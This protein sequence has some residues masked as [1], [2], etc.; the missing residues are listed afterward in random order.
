MKIDSVHAEHMLGNAVSSSISSHSIVSRDSAGDIHAAG[1]SISGSSGTLFSYSDGTRSVYGGCN[2][3]G[4]WFGTS[5]NHDLRLVT[6]SGERMRIDNTGNVGIGTTSPATYL[7]LSANNSDPGATEGDLVGTHTLTEYMR[8]TSAGDSGDVNAVS[9]GFKLG[10]DDNNNV[11][12]DGRLDICANQ[13]APAGNNY[14]TTPDKTIATFLGSGNVGIGTTDPDYKLHIVGSDTDANANY[15][16]AVIDHNCSGGGTNTGDTSHMALLIDMDSTATGGTTGNEHRMYGIKSDTRHSGDSDL[17]YGLYSYARSDHT[18]GTTTE[19]RAGDFYAIAS[20][21]GTNTNIYGINSFAY[22]DAGSTGTTAKMI[23]VRGEVQLNGGECTNAYVFQSQIDHN[24]GTMDTAYLYYGSYSGTVSTKWGIYLTG[25]TKNYF[26]G[27]VGIGVTSPGYKLHV[28]GSIYGSGVTTPYLTGHGYIAERSYT[29]NPTSNTTKYFLGWTNQDSMQIS[30]RDSGWGHGG[31]LYATVYFQWGNT[32][33]IVIHKQSG[34]YT[35]YYTY[36]NDRMYLWFNNSGNSNN[37]NIIHSIRMRTTVG[38]ISTTEPGSTETYASTTIGSSA[39]TEFTTIRLCSTR[40]GNVG[41]GTTGP[42]TLTHIGKLSANSGTHTTIPS[43]NM[44]VSASFPDSTH[45]W[46]GNHSSAEA[47]DYWG[48]ALGTLYNGNSYIQNVDKSGTNYYDL[49][50]Q[51]NGGNVG[52]GTSDPQG[53]LHI[54][55]GTSGDCHLI[56]QS[57]T[58]NNNEQDN[59]K[60]VF[61]QDGAINTAEIGIENSGGNPN[62][63]ALRGT[64]GIV[65]YDGSS[66][67]VNIDHIEDTSTEHMRIESNGNVGIGTNS[68]M[69]TGLHIANSYSASGGNTDHFNPQIFITGDSGTGGNQVSAIGFSGNSSGDTHQ[70]MVAGSVYYKGGG[71]NYGMDGYLGI[72][73]ANSSTGGADPYGLTEGELES[74]TRIAIKNNGNVGIGTASPIFPLDVTTYQHGNMTTPATWLNNTGSGIARTTITTSNF[75]DNISIRATHGIWTET[76]VG[77]I[78]GGITASDARIKKS[79]SDVDDDTA[80]Q[81][82]RQLKPKRYK[83]RDER[84]R[85]DRETIGFIAQEVEQIVPEAVTTKTG[86]TI[87][88]ILEIA[89][90]TASNILTFSDF[91]TASLESNTTTLQCYDVNNQP[92]EIT[93]ASVLND[94]SVQVKEDLSHWTASVD[95]TG[96][97][98]TETQTLTLSVEDYDALETDKGAWSA[99]TSESNV[100]ECYTQ[101]KTVYPGD[102]LY[103]QGEVVDDFH[104]LRKETIWALSTSALQEVDRQQQADKVRIAELESRVEELEAMVSII[105]LNMTWPDA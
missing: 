99:Q 98:I 105:K 97:V 57:D 5:S 92:R 51:P 16:T 2:S 25:E 44:G 41:I 27:D 26:S 3:D 102:K 85:G 24:A 65:F 11:S 23:G 60:I 86:Q 68:P 89:T 83:Y 8:F 42:K 77:G 18:S 82:L 12:P 37:N 46:L 28:N 80:L 53:R 94:R 93:I 1:V 35:F 56:L 47:E 87:P 69:T 71:G 58:D 15:Y 40:D 9:V 59:P 103:V 91:S 55:S 19:L 39:A 100:I 13:G 43:S 67:T 36:K 34:D 62:M 78:Y 50:L 17:V 63:L 52:I 88:S 73:V 48:M 33:S 90:V 49:L 61:R 96:N 95:E 70:R 72:A 74:H 22:K 79:I 7:H 54:S 14:G 81:K 75:D 38:A 104:V 66:S 45:L 6:Y 29:F 20:G 32:P 64:A 21:T 4:P 101:T 10:A 31:T 84:N 30:I 76:Y